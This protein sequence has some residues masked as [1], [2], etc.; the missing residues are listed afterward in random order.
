MTLT[1]R[2]IKYLR[3]FISIAEKLLASVDGARANAGRTSKPDKAAKSI[4]PTDQTRT[5]RSGKELVEF[6]KLLK[7]E[8]RRG[9]PVAE[10]AKK[11]GISTAYI[12]QIG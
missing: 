5:R 1:A 11:H 10:L 3:T 12:Y 2:E 6:R 8:R 7:A 4:K 9:V